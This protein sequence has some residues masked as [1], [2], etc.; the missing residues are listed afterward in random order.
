MYLTRLQIFFAGSWRLGSS[1]S[2]HR[3][4]LQAADS[5]EKIEGVVGSTLK[6]EDAT[7]GRLV[8]LPPATLL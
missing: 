8:V 7:T 6:G 3:V 4:S 1:C 5:P 2:V